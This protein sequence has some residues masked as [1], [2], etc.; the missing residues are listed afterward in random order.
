VLLQH[1]RMIFVIGTTVLAIAGSE[2]AS[3]GSTVGNWAMLVGG[4]CMMYAADILSELE[5]SARVLAT[6]TGRARTTA[7]AHVLKFHGPKGTFLILWLGAA[8]LVV[9]AALKGFGH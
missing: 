1:S 7:R 3:D 4:G 5:Q 9:G 8:L 2:V 6:S